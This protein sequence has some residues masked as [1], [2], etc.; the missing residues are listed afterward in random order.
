LTAAFN[1]K[2]SSWRPRC[3]NIFT[4]ANSIAV[5]LATLWPVTETTKIQIVDK[6]K[7]FVQFS[8]I[9]LNVNI[10]IVLYSNLMK[11][12]TFAFIF[13]RIETKKGDFFLNQMTFT[14]CGHT[15][16]QKKMKPFKTLLEC[17]RNSTAQQSLQKLL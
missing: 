14:T 7:T 13:R 2:A 4:L 9:V 3:S 11:A 10:S 8:S 6:N 1:L 16:K 15:N 12:Y 17:S 5:G